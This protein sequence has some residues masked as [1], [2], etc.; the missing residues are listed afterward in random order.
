[1]T[2]KTLYYMAKTPLYFMVAY[3]VTNRFRRAAALTPL[4]MVIDDFID[5]SLKHGEPMFYGFAGAA[6]WVFNFLS[7]DLGLDINV[8]P[9]VY[10][11][12]PLTGLPAVAVFITAV[13]GVVVLSRDAIRQGD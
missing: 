10:L 8:N 11:R 2:A 12:E 5:V 9:P 3:A 1:M 13:I 4:L 7:N 6:S